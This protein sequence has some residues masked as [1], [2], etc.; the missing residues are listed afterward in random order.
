[1]LAEA[2]DTTLDEMD[3]VLN[4]RA[5]FALESRLLVMQ[6]VDARLREATYFAGSEFTAADIMSFLAHHDAAFSAVQPAV[7]SEHPQL[8]AAHRRATSLPGRDGQG[9]SGS[10]ADA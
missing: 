8:S 7:L 2:P 3:R 10:G 4:P 1:M 9:R 5:K 6:V